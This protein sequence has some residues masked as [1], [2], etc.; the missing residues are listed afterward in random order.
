MKLSVSKILS[1]KK[2]KRSQDIKGVCSYLGMINYLE[3]F[4]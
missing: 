3:G 2:A 4:I 1:L